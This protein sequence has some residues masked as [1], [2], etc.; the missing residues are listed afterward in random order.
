[1]DE[2]ALTTVHVP[3]K[4][5]A[6]KNVKQVGQV[7]SAERGTLITTVCCVSAGG[8]AIP[9]AFIWPRKTERNLEQ[10]MKG[11]PPGSLGLVYETGWMTEDNFCKWLAHFIS[12]TKP[13]VKNPVLLILDNHISHISLQAICMAKESGVIMTTFPPH[14]TSKLQPLD[15]AVYGPLKKYFNVACNEWQLQNA[16]KTIT[17]YDVG[18][19]AGKAIPRATTPENIAS[20][21]RATGIFPLDRNVF[22]DKDF[23]PSSVTDRAAS[24][25]VVDMSANI[26]Q[27]TPSTSAVQVTTK[28]N[29]EKA[30]SITPEDIR[31]FPQAGARKPGNKRKR[32]KALVLTDTPVKNDL[33]KNAKKAVT[34]RP[35]KKKKL[36]NIEYSDSSDGESNVPIPLDDNSDEDGQDFE[37]LEDDYNSVKEGAYVVVK[38]CTKKTSATFVGQVTSVNG[39][40]DTANINFLKQNGSYFIWP[41]AADVDTVDQ[42]DIIKILTPPTSTGGTARACLKLTFDIDLQ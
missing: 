8:N 20:G 12:Y 38:Y 29:G 32:G 18:A 28:I 24:S 42:A 15:V 40:E 30:E 3:P 6:G 2:T 34:V 9:P 35:K 21:F 22:T 19:L 4:V 7:T 17:L 36:A 31:P 1:M 10:Y 13:S 11:T 5:I 39:Y 16:G 37:V 26:S 27:S 14:T 25:D 41:E 33:E 23:L